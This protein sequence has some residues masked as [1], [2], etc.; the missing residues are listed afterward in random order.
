MRVV[1]SPAAGRC[2]EATDRQVCLVADAHRIES[3]TQG[4]AV[5]YLIIMSPVSLWISQAVRNT[6]NVDISASS[7]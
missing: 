7:Q 4:L 1:S 5:S 6:V 3:R 2:N